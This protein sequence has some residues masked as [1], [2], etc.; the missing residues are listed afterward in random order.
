MHVEELHISHRHQW[1]L[2]LATWLCDEK[3]CGK[4]QVFVEERG[5]L[6]PHIRPQKPKG[7]AGLRVWASELQRMEGVGRERF[8]LYL[9]ALSAD[10]SN[11]AVSQA[12]YVHKL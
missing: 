11:C 4:H 6:M 8:Q 5:L 2:L 3:V 1:D 10:I 12:G 9:L 7:T